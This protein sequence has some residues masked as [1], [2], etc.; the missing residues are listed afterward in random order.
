MTPSCP[1]RPARRW[2]RRGP[3]LGATL[4]ASVLALGPAAGCSDDD[5][6][7]DRNYGT[8]VGAGYVL[9]DGSL[10]RVRDTGPGGDAG[11][12]AGGDTGGAEVVTGDPALDA[13]AG[14]GPVDAAVFQDTGVAADTEPGG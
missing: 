4:I 12:D 7:R 5:G 10:D 11:G 8:D 6:R 14:E 3:P 13:A 2:P 9:P 1:P